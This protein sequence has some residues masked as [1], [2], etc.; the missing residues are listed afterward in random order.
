MTLS[1]TPAEFFDVLELTFRSAPMWR[2]LND[3]ND[4][5]ANRSS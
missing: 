4:L 3:E 5:V 1:C 2:V